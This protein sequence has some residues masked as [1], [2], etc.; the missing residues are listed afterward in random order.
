MSRAR[1]YEYEGSVVIEYDHSQADGGEPTIDLVDEL[2]RE[3]PMTPL[4]RLTCGPGRM[5]E[6]PSLA[7]VLRSE[8]GGHYVGGDKVQRE[9]RGLFD[10]GFL[11]LEVTQLWLP[12]ADPGLQIGVKMAE[13]QRRMIEEGR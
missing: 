8:F 1:T 10:L 4:E 7:E 2:R 9:E 5:T 12:D 11:R 6:T 13:R 3:V